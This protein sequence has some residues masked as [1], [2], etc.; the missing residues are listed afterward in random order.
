MNISLDGRH[1]Y[2]HSFMYKNGLVC[3]KLWT[4]APGSTSKSMVNERCEN[5]NLK[6][7]M[8]KTNTDDYLDHKR[9]WT[10][11]ILVYG[12]NNTLS[13]HQ[14]FV[15]NVEAS[16]KVISMKKDVQTIFPIEVSKNLPNYLDNK[17]HF[18]WYNRNLVLDRK[19]VKVNI[20]AATKQKGR[21]EKGKIQ[22]INQRVILA[23]NISRQSDVSQTQYQSMKVN[24]SAP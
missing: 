17:I 24:Q 22:L 7:N 5:Q 6:A 11:I 19:Y 16:S 8:S 14:E 12:S 23:A 21:V 2:Y 20:C 15:C 1:P 9:F 3:L 13:N 18:T 4:M 10:Q